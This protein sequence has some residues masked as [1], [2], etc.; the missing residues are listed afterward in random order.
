MAAADKKE[1][2]VQWTHDAM[3]RYVLPDDIEDADEQVDDM[4]EI[5]TKYADSM[6]DEYE[7]RFGGGTARTS[8]KR[9]KK[10]EDEE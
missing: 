8:S 5:A 10:D 4:T 3:S 2:W 7:E 9:R 1:M 6:L